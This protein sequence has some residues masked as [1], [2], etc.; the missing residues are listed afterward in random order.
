[1]TIPVFPELEPLDMSVRTELEAAFLKQG[2]QAAEY[3]FPN[4]FAWRDF[5]SSKVTRING[6]ICI[7]SVLYKTGVCC[8][9]Q[10]VGEQRIVETLSACLGHLK[11]H[12]VPDPCIVRVPKTFLEQHDLR[13][14]FDCQEDRDNFDYV[15]LVD[16]LAKLEGR[17]YDGK[18]NHINK[19]RARGHYEYRPL[20]PDL[21]SGCMKVLDAWSKNK[22]LKEDIANLETLI[23]GEKA[24]KEY[25]KHFEVLGLIG[26]VLMKEGRVVAFTIASRLNRDTA[27]TYV[28]VSLP[29]EKG[30]NQLLNQEF[31]LHGLKEFTYVNREQDL[32]HEG[33]RKAKM[34]YHPH[35]LLEKFIIRNKK[36]ET[37]YKV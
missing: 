33:L 6:N 18:R 29:D 34:S 2:M 17:K 23:F 22:F 4:L 10:P 13:A 24:I 21:I 9:A 3:T 11:A 37:R 30:L 12:D 15:Y 14:V 35:H 28:E 8:F 36:Q 31:C 5:D 1:M 16:D 27:V 25:L 20:S 7:L 26:G 19:V 32:G